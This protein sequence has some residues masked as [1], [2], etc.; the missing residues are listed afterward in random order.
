MS[1]QLLPRRGFLIVMFLVMLLCFCIVWFRVFACLLAKKV[2]IFLFISFSVFTFLQPFCPAYIL[3]SSKTSP[4]CFPEG[5]S[6]SL[7]KPFPALFPS[8][9]I[10]SSA[11]HR[12]K[13][14][15]ACQRR[16]LVCVFSLVH[17]LPTG[18]S[19]YLADFSVDCAEI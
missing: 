6:M 16:L 9:S 18:W 13:S 19:N 14:P 4:F 12:K 17:T 10:C 2:R 8:V 7:P 5:S 3:T 1:T 11:R 15:S